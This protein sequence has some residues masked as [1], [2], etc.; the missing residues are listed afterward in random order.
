VLPFGEVF[1]R[2]AVFDPVHGYAYLGQDSRPNQIVKIKLAKDT[3]VITSAAK[4]PGGAF[5]FG[6]TFTPGVAC[7]ALAATNPALPITDWDVLGGV[8]EVAPGQF[9]FNDSP[10][11]NSPLRFYR[12]RSP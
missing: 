11:T 3:P 9:Q 8:T 7:A 4:L 2:S 12:F 6:F 1:I 5:Q 10:A